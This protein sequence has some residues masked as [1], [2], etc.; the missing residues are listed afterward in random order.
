MRSDAFLR[1]WTLKESVLKA[2]GKGLSQPLDSFRVA[3]APDGW[4]LH[5]LE[6]APGYLGAVA[7]QAPAC[8]LRCFTPA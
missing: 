1:C 6:P 8:P 5:A 4:S 7:V 2:T 3:G